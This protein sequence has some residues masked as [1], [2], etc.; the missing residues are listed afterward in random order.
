MAGFEVTPEA[1]KTGTQL[2]LSSQNHEFIVIRL[3]Q[4]DQRFI[5]QAFLRVL[6]ISDTDCWDMDIRK[7]LVAIAYDKFASQR[8]H[9]LY[10]ASFWPLDDL[11]TDSGLPEFRALIGTKLL[12]GEHG[13]LVRLSFC[14]YRLFE[15]L[16]RDLSNQSEIIKA[17]FEA[18]RFLVSS[19]GHEGDEY[20]IFLD[21]AATPGA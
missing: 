5:W 17:Q 15:Q 6:R 12:P 1:R 8:N 18:S 14:V 21:Q 2:R 19:Q 9:F 11:I 7:E 10:K 3:P 4:L 20:R 16:M 13:F